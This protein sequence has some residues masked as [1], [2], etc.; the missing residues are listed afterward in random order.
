MRVGDGW[1]RGVTIRWRN[2]IIFP[3]AT[4]NF[5]IRGYTT[6]LFTNDVG[7]QRS[8]VKRIRHYGSDRWDSGVG[9][10]RCFI[11]HKHPKHLTK[12]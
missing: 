7:S 5:R 10:I 3:G 1:I 6:S 8:I 11:I 4:L 2:F 12:F 9:G